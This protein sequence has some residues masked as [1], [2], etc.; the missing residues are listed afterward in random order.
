MDYNIISGG[1]RWVPPMPQKLARPGT[2]TDTKEG[3]DHRRI[4]IG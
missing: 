1:D 3:I 4:L 2:F